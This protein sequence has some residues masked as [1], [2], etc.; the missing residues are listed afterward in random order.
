MGSKV[1]SIDVGS[2]VLHMVEGSQVGS[3]NVRVSRTLSFPLAANIIDNG[4][5]INKDIFVSGLVEAVEKG[6]FTAKK[7]ILTVGNTA[8]VVKDVDLPNTKSNVFDALIRNEMQEVLNDETFHIIEYRK[9]YEYINDENES[10][11]KFRVSAISFDVVKAFWEALNE[12]GLNPIA[13]DI[14]ANAVDKLL[15]ENTVINGLNSL[16]RGSFVAL[17]FGYTGTRIQIYTDGQPDF[18]RQILMGTKDLY[19]LIPPGFSETP[20]ETERWKGLDLSKSDLENAA[21]YT[22]LK[23]FFLQW[24]NELRKVIQYHKVARRGKILKRVFLYGGGALIKGLP[25]YL[26]QIFDI[27]FENFSSLNRVQNQKAL[28]ENGLILYIKAIGAIIR[29]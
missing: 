17:D 18:I 20:D 15:T 29:L 13:M 16:S 4:V 1:L 22:A 3:R 12:A 21:M 28:G 19:D 6:K 7:V 27:P 8:A 25:A 5:I 2:R 10:K 23:P 9:L 11:V 24:T 26:N 14:N